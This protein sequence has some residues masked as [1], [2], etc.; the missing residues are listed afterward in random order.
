LKVPGPWAVAIHVIDGL[1]ATEDVATVGSINDVNYDPNQTNAGVIGAAVF[2]G[3]KQSYVVA[4][5][6]QDGA[7]SATMTYGVPAASAS[8]HVVFDAPEDGNGKSMV[9]AAVDG[10]R[11]AITVTAGDGIAGHPLMFQ[12]SGAAD[13]CTITEDTNVAPGTPPPG[14]GA[15]GKGGGQGGQA[16]PSG[17]TGGVAGNNLTGGAVS[18]CG[19]SLDACAHGGRTLFFSAVALALLAGACWRRRRR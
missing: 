11:C 18:G 9:S 1:A 19:C 6:A 16:G 3:S 13:G 2:R 15:A 5:A 10:S 4:S 8:R 12:V 7:I 17:G 14:G